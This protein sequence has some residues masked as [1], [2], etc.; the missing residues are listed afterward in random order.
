MKKKILTW[1][2][3]CCMVLQSTESVAFAAEPSA[4]L[5]GG[6]VSGNDGTDE[7]GQGGTEDG[8][9]KEPE[10]GDAEDGET[11]KPE[12]DDEITNPEEDGAEASETENS[13]EDS[14]KD[15]ET[16]APEEG[17]IED[18][19]TVG[20]IKSAEEDA[21]A[22][23]KEEAIGEAIS[24]NLASEAEQK[25][26]YAQSQAESSSVEESFLTAENRAAGS[27]V[28]ASKG[29]YFGYAVLDPAM[30]TGVLAEYLSES[31]NIVLPHKLGNYYMTGIDKNV[32]A[33]MNQKDPSDMSKLPSQ[34]TSGK[35]LLSSGEEKILEL[36]NA[37]RMKEGKMP[38][39]M[40]STLRETARRKSL[41]MLNKNYFD[42]K[43]TDGTYTS[44]WLTKCGY[45]WHMWAENIAYNYES[46]ER[47][48]NQWWNST[49]HRNNMM[50]SSLRAIGIGVYKD[51]N[52]RIMGTQVF[53]STV[54]QNLTSVRIEYGYETIGAGAF[55]GCT[56]LK[57]I[58]IPSTVT[59]IAEDAFKGCDVLTI[60]GKA[61]SYAQSFA[62]AK[63]IPFESVAETCPIQKF[64]YEQEEVFMEK[65]DVDS[66]SLTIEP[67]EYRHL[68][69]EGEPVVEQP[70]E[71]QPEESE[72]ETGTK[73]QKVIAILED[74]TIRA[75]ADGTVTLTAQAA[76]KE[77]TCRITVGEKNV[78]IQD[79][80]F[81]EDSIELYETE[82]FTPV[83]CVS[84]A[85]ATQGVQ[86]L[87]SNSEVLAVEAGGTVK[88]L[89]AGTASLTVKAVD[90]DVQAVLEVQVLAVKE[91]L[92]LPEGLKAVTNIDK[93]LANVPL[94]AYP[95][96]SWK[97]PQT[98][99]QAKKGETIQY[100]A[101][102]YT[103]QHTDGK[104][105]R[106]DCIIPVEVS[107]ASGQRVILEGKTLPATKK[108]SLSETYT[109]YPGL[110]ATGAEVDASFYEVNAEANK[111]EIL[112]AETSFSENAGW[113]IQITPRSAGKCVVTVE[114]KLK[115][116]NGGYGP[117]KKPYGTY[118]KKYTFQVEEALYANG[119]KIIPA[120]EMAEGVQCTEDG[121]FLV[122][123]GVSKF[124]VRA[125]ALDKSG[126]ETDT[127]LTFG[128]DKSGVIQVRAVKGETGL[129]E[130]TVKKIGEAALSVTAKDNG[131]RS[132]SVSIC[133]QRT[134]PQLQNKT[135][136]LNKWKPAVTVPVVLEEAENNPIQKVALY[137]DKDCQNDSSLFAINKV[138]KDDGTDIDE[139]DAY[140]VGFLGQNTEQIKK[141][142]YKVYLQ[143]T[144]ERIQE[145]QPEQ[146][147]QTQ[148][149]TQQTTQPRTYVYP[150]TI[151]LKNTKPSVTLK[152]SAQINLFYKDADAQLAISSGTE[153]INQI[154]QINEIT[155]APHFQV[156]FKQEGDVWAGTISPV[157]VTA[158]NYKKIKKTVELQFLFQDYGE[159]YVLTKKLTVKSN[160]QK[161]TLTTSPT[162]ALLYL[163]TGN[164]RAIFR[165]M[166]KKS[167]EILIPK[168]SGNTGENVEGNIT[169]TPDA[170]MES[171]AQFHME[172]G[173]PDI[174]VRLLGTKSLT[175]KMKVSHD[176]WREPVSCSFKMTV[177]KKTP[178]LTLD[179]TKVSLNTN[180]AG[181]EV[182]S[183]KA[184]ANKNETV[185]IVRLKEADIVGANGA[186]KKLLEEEKLSI[187]P[188]RQGDSRT[189]T[190]RL[191]DSSVKNGTYKYKVYGW[192]MVG[193]TKILRMNPVT[194]S[195]T[196]SNK[197][198]SVS[199]KAK[200]KIK[201]SDLAGGEILYTPKIANVTGEIRSASLSGAYASAFTLTP[202]DNGAY[203]IKAKD[204]AGLNKGSY[205]LYM[206][207]GLENGVSVTSK[208]FTVKIQ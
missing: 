94:D 169:V 45:P 129:A 3:I 201:A 80:R 78:A 84:P 164:D 53:S 57:S 13:E 184:S 115:D 118:K 1:V 98:K 25:V 171:K 151:K 163:A 140:A 56:N 155:G 29:L 108:L 141:G 70:V 196:V 192:C 105:I 51:S 11:K 100:F 194:L 126:A 14:E 161:T 170:G 37:A 120:Q 89:K 134:S 189:L 34:S 59:E 63:N 87:S 150:I 137:E 6:T 103:E 185:S 99:L 66:V 110:N 145:G 124:R 205:K 101:A 71:T 104:T 167:K 179:K 128:T 52:G 127:A 149:Q 147:G 5:Q 91:D 88:A 36:V 114:I 107:A 182:F 200:G 73:E 33:N 135:W 85:D 199:L 143:V 32:F 187:C 74:G 72:S 28:K 50:H 17:E 159:E 60:Y 174:S 109:L 154:R 152:Q 177:N 144:T 64:C 62:A 112:K 67:A 117:A 122:E 193:E 186:A 119:F 136:T 20:R 157:G 168:E 35:T 176:N 9:M 204:G 47:L 68:I 75:L 49:G 96:F 26:Q 7:P 48:Y 10:E 79:V 195:V 38:L 82:V 172:P 92:S 23:D 208:A 162:D 16:E 2:I 146:Q 31:G 97:E 181:R 190:V 188:Q 95:G 55:S 197:Q 116:R 113:A 106:Q 40:S 125:Y 153:K 44:D 54:F 206:T 207:F 142:S 139:A 86:L 166:D 132:V 156:A 83:Y 4:G 138:K 18:S 183:L 175:A 76:E 15:V 8:G 133:V 203:R 93:T 41:D 102:Q 27:A 173:S 81:Y 43:N 191:N 178:T 58:T 130:V 121:S 12:E 42:H 21:E 19:E 61:G 65:G 165:I 158:D 123:E 39:I 198:P 46:A 160:Y 30:H 180:A 77:A 202:G 24:L 69:K 131:K 148:S 111:E 90:S 22:S